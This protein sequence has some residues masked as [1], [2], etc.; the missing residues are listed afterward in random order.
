MSQPEVLIVFDLLD[1]I[2]F[3]LSE[4]WNA[5]FPP[6]ELEELSRIWGKPIH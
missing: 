1:R 4:R 2:P 3:K 6:S 5:A